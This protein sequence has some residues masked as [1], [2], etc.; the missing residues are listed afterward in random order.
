[1]SILT[2]DQH[3]VL[4]WLVGLKNDNRIGETFR[5][6]WNGHKGAV[7][8]DEIEAVPELTG[9]N[10]LDALCL[11]ELLICK[12]E[13]FNDHSSAMPSRWVSVLR[14][15][16]EL[17]R[18]CT[19]TGRAFVLAQTAVPLITPDQIEG[20]NLPALKELIENSFN[21]DELR[22]IYFYLKI[23]WNDLAGDSRQQKII[24]LVKYYERRDSL[25][26]LIDHI[27]TVRPRIPVE[28]IKL[29]MPNY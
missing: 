1:M 22:D 27:L 9:P 17:V 15:P 3:K 8:N 21:E 13:M 10:V 28:K 24:E 25:D 23:D 20:I 7:I 5:V 2:P 4:K 16:T 6:Q 29:V 18:N 12:I 14:E 26:I 19:F 11:K